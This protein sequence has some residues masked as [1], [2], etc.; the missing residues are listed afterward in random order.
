MSATEAEEFRRCDIGHLIDGK[1]KMIG[2]Y[3][4]ASPYRYHGG[5]GGYGPT[6]KRQNVDRAGHRNRQDGSVSTIPTLPPEEIFWAMSKSKR[7]KLLK[8]VNRYYK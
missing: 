5:S 4:H 3:R 8:E 6:G 7:R 2:H 1:G